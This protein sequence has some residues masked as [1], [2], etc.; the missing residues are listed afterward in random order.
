LAARTGATIVPIGIGNSDLAMPKGSTIPKP[1]K[2]RVVVGSPMAPPERSS[3]GRV[4][5]SKVHATTTAL[6]GE[7][8]AVYDQ[9]RLDA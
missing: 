5:R 1:L 9:A 7:I 3:A 4:S 8:Q 6:Q 2:I